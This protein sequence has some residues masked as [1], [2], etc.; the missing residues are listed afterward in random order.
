MSATDIIHG[1]HAAGWGGPGREGPVN[2][3]Y[4]VL[5][6]EIW[7][8]YVYD[9]LEV[10]SRYGPCIAKV[11]GLQHA[12][13]G[14]EVPGDGIKHHFFYLTQDEKYIYRMQAPAEHMG[15]VS[16]N[17]RPVVLTEFQATGGGALVSVEGD[18][19]LT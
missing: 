12:V 18:I 1:C 19:F 11:I 4:E 7:A 13:K 8:E 2:L 14:L 17:R 15:M 9:F 5:I 10:I 6:R 3:L 16:T